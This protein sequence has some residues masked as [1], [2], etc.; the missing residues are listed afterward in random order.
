MKDKLMQKNVAEIVVDT[1]VKAGGEALLGIVGDT[2]NHFTDAVRTSDLN[3]VGVRHEEV[4]AFAAGGEAFMTG[5]WRFAPNLRSR[6]PSF[7][8][9]HF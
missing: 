3:W 8:Q 6:Q 9:R 1:L 4:G 2:I 7:P 5:E